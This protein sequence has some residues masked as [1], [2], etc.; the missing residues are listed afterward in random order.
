MDTQIFQQKKNE[1]LAYKK[2][3]FLI[4]CY[5]FSFAAS[6]SSLGNKILFSK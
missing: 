5:L 6:A 1:P 4:D 2:S 3:S